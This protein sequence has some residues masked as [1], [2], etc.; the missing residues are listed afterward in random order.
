MYFKLALV[1]ATFGMV[2]GFATTIANLEDCTENS[3]AYYQATY[4]LGNGKGCKIGELGYSKFYFEELAASLSA[5]D[6]GNITANDLI[7]VPN[8][9]NNSFSILPSNL[10]EFNRIVTV[11]ERYLI[12]YFVDPPPI[13]AGDELTLDPPVGNIYATKFGCTEEDFSPGAVSI[14]ARLLQVGRAGYGESTFSCG[15][16]PFNPYVLKTNGTDP[17]FGFVSDSITFAQPVSKLYIRMVLDFEP[18]E[19]SGFEGILNPIPTTTTVPE[20]AVNAMMA[21]GLGVIGW[22]ARRKR[23]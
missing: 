8:F 15:S 9:G 22:M 4:S 17:N 19:I 20:P 1:F 21:A 18:G 14:E 5:P 12:S 6:S 16:T 13:I 11:A 10:N 3:L 23:S 7:I 2:H